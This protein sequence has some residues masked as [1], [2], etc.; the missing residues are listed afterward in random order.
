MHAHSRPWQKG[1]PATFVARLLVAATAVTLALSVV[2]HNDLD[3]R[4]AATGSD[5]A[6]GDANCDGALN[7]IDASLALQV[8]VGLLDRPGCEDAADVSCDGVISSIDAAI[9]LQHSAGLID[10][11]GLAGCWQYDQEADYFMFVEDRTLGNGSVRFTYK[12][13]CQPTRR[14]K[15][16][17]TAIVRG[18]QVSMSGDDDIGTYTMEAE[19]SSDG[20]R[21][22]GTRD[23]R[24]E[25]PEFPLYPIVL[26]KGKHSKWRETVCDLFS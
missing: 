22:S 3:G 19:L 2:G 12:E 24:E 25:I 23:R 16:T 4:A 17:G 18:N 13:I 8:V 5:A 21:L 10:L 7:S 26:V 9:I 6:T 20:T 1:T 11:G 15:G 14:V